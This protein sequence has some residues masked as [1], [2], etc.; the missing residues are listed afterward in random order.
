MPPLGPIPSGLAFIVGQA[1]GG[2]VIGGGTST[3]VSSATVTPAGTQFNDNTFNVRNL[4]TSADDVQII[5]GRHQFSFGGWLQRVQVNANAVSQLAGEAKFTSL[6]TFLQGTTSSF[7]GVPNFT[8]LYWRQIEGAWY[9]QDN[10]HLGSNLTLRLG[11]RHELTNGWNEAHGHAAQFIPDA[12][13]VLETNPR[14]GTSAFVDNNAIKLFS[15]RVGVAWDP[16]GKGK[17]SIRAGFGTYYTLLDNLSF[18][19]AS[20]PPFNT[21][22]S[23]LNAS[24]PSLVP[25]STLPPGCGPGVPKPCTTYTPGGVQADAQTP[26]VFEWNFTVEQQLTP[27][28]SLRVAYVGSRN[29][30]NII[31]T[32]SNTI[33][34]LICSNP[35]GC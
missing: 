27:N 9:A 26:T 23:F 15:P 30:H 3:Q 8:V 14:L 35:A 20:T 1:P 28:M 31:S 19:L 7:T 18:R 16:F 24:F 2:I 5:R 17:T 29:Y 25:V 4:F 6:Q 22:F 13:G 12:S 33:A 34:P 32:D 11:L 21:S 10:V